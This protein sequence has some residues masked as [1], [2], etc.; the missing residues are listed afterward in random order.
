M[1][2][3]VTGSSGLIGRALVRELRLAGHTVRR[4]LR[5]APPPGEPAL[6]WDPARGEIDGAGLEGVD[7]MVHLAGV[8]VGDKRWTEE[9]KQAILQSRVTGTSLLAGTL[10]GLERKPSVLVSAS[11]IDYYGETGD[12]VVTEASPPGTGFM[13]EVCQRWEQAT[14]PAADAGIR[15][16]CIRS[17]AVQ[18]PAG[19]ALA[20]M[21]PIF[22]AGIGGRLGTG[23]QWWSWITLTDEVRAIRFLLDDQRAGT[24]AGPVNLSSPNPV[25]NADYVKELGRVLHRPAVIPAP[26]FGPWLLFGRELFHSLALASHRVLPTVLE[27]TGFDFVHA[28][29]ADGLRAELERG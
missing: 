11:G 4:V 21:V 25:T 20:R 15:V 1:D 23:R 12:H 18:S 7:A 5:S 3:A 22:K 10:A 26:A 17:A 8:G 2:V 19:G 27:Q 9:R 13:A 29:L 28:R 14:A 6:R 24:V 16:A